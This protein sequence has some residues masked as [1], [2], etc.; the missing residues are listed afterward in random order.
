MKIPSPVIRVMLFEDNTPLRESLSRLI[1]LYPEFTLAGAYNNALNIL[2]HVNACKPDVI[3]MDIDMPG[4]S[5]IEA[6]ELVHRSHP[7]TRVLMQTVFDDDDKIF[8]SICAGAVGY[9][10]KQ[11]KPTDI[12]Q[13]I[14]EAHEGGSPMTPEVATKVLKMFRQ[15]SPPTPD[16]KISLSDREKEVLSA[17]TLGKSYKMIAE[18]CTISIDTVRFHIKNIY[19]KLHVH[20]MTEAVSKALREKLI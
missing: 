19:E 3:L 11:S 13:S 8:R 15:Y 16:Q 5:G 7:G 4:I 17:L 18:S 9:I 14:R 1:E 10:L 20:S 2:A 6:V 12:L